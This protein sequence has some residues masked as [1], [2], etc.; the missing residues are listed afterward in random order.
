MF[1][2]TAFSF[3]YFWSFQVSAWL[4]LSKQYSLF[5]DSTALHVVRWSGFC[6]TSQVGAVKAWCPSCVAL[7]IISKNEYSDSFVQVIVVWLVIYSSS[8]SSNKKLMIPLLV[9][10][11]ELRAYTCGDAEPVFT[12]CSYPCQLLFWLVCG[13]FGFEF[14]VGCIS[15]SC[16]IHLGLRGYV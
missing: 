15:W 5:S 14:N 12:S 11:I 8:S 4:T 3:L 10:S 1:L 13:F 16:N 9:R 7:I 2:G 6:T